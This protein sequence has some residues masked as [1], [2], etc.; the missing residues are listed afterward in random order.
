MLG[1]MKGLLVVGM[2]LLLSACGGK[3]EAKRDPNVLRVGTISGPETELVEVAKEVAYDKYGL[4]VE[5]V[6]FEDYVLPNT[7]LVDGAI[8]VNVYQ[9]KPYLDNY[10]E[11][12][13]RCLVV[14]GETFVYPVAIYSKKYTSLDAIPVKAKIAIPN[15]PSNGARALLLMQDAGLIKLKPKNG[16]DF[17]VKDITDNPKQLQFVEL[18]AAQL[19]RVLQD[20]DAAVINTN[21][22]MQAGLLPDRDGLFTETADSPYANVI[23]VMNDKKNEDNVQLFVHAM[24][25]KDV[26][27]KASELF[28]GQAIKAW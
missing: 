15:D 11:K 16:F 20:V 22:S 8:D 24:Q 18:D 23:V 7:A 19:P 3:E 12:T 27:A 6:E 9:H 1:K 25:S 17:T 4:K 5:V 21:Y 26:E 28:Q 14:A 2:A 10:I 13:S